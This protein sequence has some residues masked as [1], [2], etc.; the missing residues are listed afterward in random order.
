MRW[1][2]KDYETWHSHFAWL[3]IKINSEWVWLERVL[4]KGRARINVAKN[5]KWTWEFV[6]S[7]F[8]LIKRAEQEKAWANEAASGSAGN[9]A[10]LTQI[11]KR[12]GTI[13][14]GN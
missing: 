8:D 12:A 4:R 6:N 13:P 3:P 14:K 5:A 10:A 2:A 1:T 9:A 7:E 11:A